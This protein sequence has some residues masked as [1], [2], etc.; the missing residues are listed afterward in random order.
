MDQRLLYFY[1]FFMVK[2]LKLVF[3]LTLSPYIVI[4]G[5]NSLKKC[6]NI[7]GFSSESDN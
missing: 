6:I 7:S 5:E 2:I 1:I 3:W 4:W